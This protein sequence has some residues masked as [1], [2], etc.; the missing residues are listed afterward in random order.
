MR[1]NVFENLFIKH[2]TLFMTNSRVI[3]GLLCFVC[4]TGVFADENDNPAQIVDSIFFNNEESRLFVFA[5]LSD[6]IP[7]SHH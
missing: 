5:L 6:I 3:A 7:S 2:K 1:T 4:T